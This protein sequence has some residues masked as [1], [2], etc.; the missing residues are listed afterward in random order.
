MRQNTHTHTRPEQ[1]T[2]NPTQHNRRLIAAAALHRMSTDTDLTPC[3]RDALQECAQYMWNN[4]T[5][6]EVDQ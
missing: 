2:N 4:P 3:D 5:W 6:A 1:P